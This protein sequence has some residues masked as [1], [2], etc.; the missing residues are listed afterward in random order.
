[1]P[2]WLGHYALNLVVFA[3]PLV[4]MQVWQH[5]TNDLLA[6]LRLPGWLTGVIEGGLLLGIVL[7]WEKESTPFIYF[8][9]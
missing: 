7:F 4:L 9:F 5:R 2:A 3:A 6:P 1:V 8:Q